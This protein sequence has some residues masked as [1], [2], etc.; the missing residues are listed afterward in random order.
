M[1]IP[2]SIEIFK[3]YDLLD[4]WFTPVYEEEK[5]LKKIKELEERAANLENESKK[6][7]YRSAE[8]L[9]LA[10]HLREEINELRK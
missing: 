8:L 6:L 3:K 4:I 5:D 2:P 7:V 10:K 9:D 1:N